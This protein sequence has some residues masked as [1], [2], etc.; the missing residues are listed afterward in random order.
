MTKAK[1]RELSP[2]EL[3]AVIGGL[4]VGPDRAPP[5]G[6]FGVASTNQTTPSASSGRFKSVDGGDASSD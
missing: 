1:L 3:D 6:Y 4:I 5:V 2:A